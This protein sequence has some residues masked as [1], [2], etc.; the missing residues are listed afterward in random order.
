MQHRSATE[1]LGHSSAE[2]G[3]WY[4][5]EE[6]NLEWD[7]RHSAKKKRGGV[8]EARARGLESGRSAVKDRSME[9]ES[10]VLLLFSQK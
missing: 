6:E 4:G 5:M 9:E 2:E 7:V 3:A 1:L 10:S 8:H